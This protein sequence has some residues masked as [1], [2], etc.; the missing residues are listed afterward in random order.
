MAILDVGRVCMKAAGREAGKFCVVLEK[1]KDDFVLV[2]GPKT[3][4]R[5]KRRK[6]NILHLEPTE[7]KLNISQDAEDS[8]VDKAWKASELIEKYKIIV[9]TK[10]KQKKAEK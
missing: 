9:P 5:I 8:A 4:T 2:T 7:D 10:F 6:C 1:P 3:I